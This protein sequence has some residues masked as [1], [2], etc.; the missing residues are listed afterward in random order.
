MKKRIKKFFYKIIG[1]PQWCS[2]EDCLNWYRSKGLRIGE[3]CTVRDPKDIQIDITRPELIEIGNNVLLHKGTIILSHDWAGRML[4][5][6]YSLFLPSHGK[7]KIGNNVWLGENVTILK[8]VEIGDNVIIG[9][10]SIVTKS[11]P[12]DS[13][14]VGI[15]ARVVSTIKDYYDKRKVESVEET[16]E[17][18]IAI[19]ESG[20]TP[21][22]EDFY[23]DYPAFVDGSNYKDYNYPYSHIFSQEEFEIWK[24]KYKAPYSSFD[25]F[26][27]AVE[28]RINK[29]RN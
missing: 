4:L 8:N 1:K 26:L 14:A 23:D 12:S 6:K 2:S 20:R 3:G 18:A 21:V 19:Y 13:V 17:Y 11:I 7:V 5:K 28:E 25:A 9:T 29:T 24:K 27:K 15:P 16:I 22:V 10:G